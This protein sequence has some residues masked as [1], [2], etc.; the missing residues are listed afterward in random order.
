MLGVGTNNM[1]A[2]AHGESRV[3][4]RLELDGNLLNWIDASAWNLVLIKN[5]PMIDHQKEHPD[6]VTM[7]V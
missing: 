3:K 7:D 1:R 5:S 4:T 2:G 6:F